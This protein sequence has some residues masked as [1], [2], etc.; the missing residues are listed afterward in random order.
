M[1]ASAGTSFSPLLQQGETPRSLLRRSPLQR[2]FLQKGLQP[3]DTAVA[4]FWRPGLDESTSSRSPLK[5][6]SMKH[7]AEGV[8]R[9]P[10]AEARQGSQDN[11]VVSRSLGLRAGVSAVPRR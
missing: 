11:I 4:P 10:R 7:H 3:H 5:G 6:T 1:P 8:A 2:G 9:R